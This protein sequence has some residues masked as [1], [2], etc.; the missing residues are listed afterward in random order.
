MGDEQEP[1]SSAGRLALGGR[2]GYRQ[3]GSG[4]D[5]WPEGAWESGQSLEID[6]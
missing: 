2:P 6:S 3:L 1:G 4:E 5:I